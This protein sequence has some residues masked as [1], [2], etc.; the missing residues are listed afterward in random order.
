MDARDHGLSW[1]RRSTQAV[2]TLQVRG[3]LVGCQLG[4]IAKGS[5][6]GE[7]SFAPARSRRPPPP[8]DRLP[9]PSPRDSRAA[10]LA[11]GTVCQARPERG[12]LSRYR[13]DG[14][15][16][17]STNSSI[18][19]SGTKARQGTCRQRNVHMSYSSQRNR[20][21]SVPR[22]RIVDRLSS[23]RLICVKCCS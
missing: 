2:H 18:R 11:A 15:V 21:C 22:P 19:R 8:R 3:L 4:H 14:L 1:R 7:F 23:S 12:R 6:K 5:L 9:G 17:R 13:R 20:I 16:V 10:R